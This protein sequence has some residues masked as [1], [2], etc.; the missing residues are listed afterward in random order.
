MSQTLL[1]LTQSMNMAIF[2]R[3]T[4]ADFKLMSFKPEWLEKLC[5]PELKTG[6]LLDLHAQ[7]PYIE[8]FLHEAE[9]IWNQGITTPHRSGPWLQP[10]L[11]KDEIP[12][13]ALALCSDQHS[14]LILKDLGTEYYNLS[15]HLQ[16]SRDLVLHEEQLQAAVTKASQ[17]IRV[18]EEEITVKLISAASQR[19]KE[20]AE[21]VRCIGLYAEVMAKALGWNEALAADIRIAARMHDIG[22]I[23]IPDRILLKSGKLTEAEFEVMKQHAAIGADMLKGTNIALLGM[24]SDIALYHHERWDG[25][26]YPRGLKGKEIPESARIT[27]ILDVYDTLCNKR[28]YKAAINEEEALEMMSEMVGIHFDPE[29]YEVFLANLPKIQAIKA[30]AVQSA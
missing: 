15:V 22:K 12:L 7:L 11:D 13:E 10:T 3:E 25:S 14:I 5:A 8:R 16:K 23:G 1:H 26:G 18:R 20:T 29:L 17:D 6:H 30:A 27:T 9:G 2:V 24:A 4:K 21:H 19:D 28:R